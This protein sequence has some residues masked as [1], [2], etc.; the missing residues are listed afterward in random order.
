MYLQCHSSFS[1]QYG[2]IPPDRLAEFA[3]SCAPERLAL[4]DINCMAAHAEFAKACDRLGAAYLLGVDFRYKNRLQ[5]ILIARNEAGYAFINAH[6][7]ERNAE[8]AYPGAPDLYPDFPDSVFALY[9]P[10]T[11]P[12]KAP[13][14]VFMM[15]RP[16][17]LKHRFSWHRR[18]PEHRWVACPTLTF[19]HPRM[20]GFHRILRAIGENELL[21]RLSADKLSDPDDYIRSPQAVEKLYEA[22]P[23]TIHR[24]RAITDACEFRLDFT[25]NRTLRFFYGSDTEDARALRQL[26]EIGKRKRYGD[27]PPPEAEARIE[28][29]LRVIAELNFQAYY[30][31]THDMIRFAAEQG[32]RHVGRGSGANSIVAYCLGITDVDPISLDLYFER[33][34]NASRNSPPDFDIDFS[35]KDRDA[36]IRYI[37]NRYN[38]KGMKASQLSATV[39]YK[40]RA[41]LRELGKIFGMPKRDIDK[42]TGRLPQ[43]YFSTLEPLIQTPAS[44]EDISGSPLYNRIIRISA[45]LHKLPSHLSIHAGGILIA[46]DSLYLSTATFVP[47]KGFPVAQIDMFAADDLQLHKLDILSQRGLGHITDTLSLI[48]HTKG[49]AEA[50]AA[51]AVI[52]HTGS[53]VDNPEAR[54]LLKTGDTIGCFY[55]ES[56]AM[57]SLILK[58]R[59]DNFRALTAASSVIRPGVGH[60]GM[61]RAFIAR[62]RGDEPVQ[63]LHPILTHLLKETFGVMIYQED[64]L[65][66]AHHFGGLSLE[67]ADILRRGMSGKLRSVEVLRT[68]KDAFLQSCTRRGIDEA[69][70]NEVW[71]QME[72]FSGY[73]FPKAHSASFA[74]ES[75]QDL[76]LKHTYPLEFMTAVI[77][78][79]GGFYSTA[80]YLEEAKRLGAV[81]LIP[82]VNQSEYLSTLQGNTIRLGFIHV[83]QLEKDM[84]TGLLH[85]RK[86]YGPFAGV[87]DF[88]QRVSCGQEQVRHL[89]RLGCF[90]FT[91][92]PRASMLWEARMS[93]AAVVAGGPGIF[94]VQQPDEPE[95]PLAHWSLIQILHIEIEYLGFPVTD[96]LF[97]L[98]APLQ[99]HRISSIHMR[100]H[101]GQY[102]CM[103]GCIC[104]RKPIRTRNGKLMQFL[105][106]RDP[107]GVW[108][109]VLFP[110]LNMNTELRN[111][112]PWILHGRI[113]LDFDVPVLDIQQVQL[114]ERLPLT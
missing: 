40:H 76:Y 35:W 98:I 24:A 44:A 77:N 99:E 107:E 57:R 41:V 114:A 85:N 2:S 6:L 67:Q 43:Q 49:P 63:C 7:S 16:V 39:R 113:A 51:K 21:D 23:E 61:M 37:L 96:S 70:T 89:I 97:T 33:F 17:D 34:L 31:L 13:N 80:F 62:F 32:S 68:L 27:T 52:D 109:G 30:L 42:F 4:T 29:E 82:C 95:F 56:P 54:K 59:C 1:F 22:M 8:A 104:S 100:Q 101:A 112:G 60:S 26:T 38:T 84:I 75:F 47:P 83:A 103:V 108:D 10:D 102:V 9:P 19:E 106:F 48:A 50:Q 65:K 20:F 73:T 12:V 46:S 5:Y 92:R 88:L 86:L 45:Y 105:T 94:G 11:M 53:I 36:I 25:R 79:F 81:V 55:I 74:V 64:V 18:I 3:A 90:D 71:R 28:K 58:L 87:H 72:S 93:K 111:E 78:N 66:V 14:H 110:K 91:G 69:V 15:V